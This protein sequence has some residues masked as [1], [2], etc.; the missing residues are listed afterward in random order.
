MGAAC[1][2]NTDTSVLAL[3]ESAEVPVET[4]ASVER[5]EP[6]SPPS[7]EPVKAPKQNAEPPTTI[8]AD[9][10][11]PVVGDSPPPP[12]AEFDREW[13]NKPLAATVLSEADLASLGLGDG[14]TTS[15]IE[16]VGDVASGQSSNETVCGTPAPFPN[17]HIAGEFRNSQTRSSLQFVVMP[18]GDGPWSG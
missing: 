9:V 4:V 3:G 10:D 17:A 11:E 14:W 2:Q 7:T 8:P 16:W 5:V 15:S 1:S 6:E 13:E 12:A 18:A